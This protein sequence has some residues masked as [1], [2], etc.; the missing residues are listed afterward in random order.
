MG[1]VMLFRLIP[2][3]NT[4]LSSMSF[5]YKNVALSAC[6]DESL[7]WIYGGYKA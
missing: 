1:S 7:N 3:Y 4:L 6:F 5:G 2:T